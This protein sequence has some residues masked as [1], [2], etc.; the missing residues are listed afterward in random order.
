MP[1]TQYAV[2]G[3]LNIAFQVIGESPRDLVY[4]PG[5]VSNTEVM[6][7]DPGLAWLQLGCISWRTVRDRSRP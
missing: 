5:W 3:D 1:E 4:V 2:N 6:W 7:E